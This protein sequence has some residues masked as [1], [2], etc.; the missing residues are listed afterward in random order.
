M[1]TDEVLNVID[2][3]LQEVNSDQKER[4]ARIVQ[5]QK[6]LSYN[7]RLTK[8]TDEEKE[9]FVESVEGGHMTDEMRKTIDNCKTK[10]QK[11]HYYDMWARSTYFRKCA[12]MSYLHGET[13][14]KPFASK[15]K[16][17]TTSTN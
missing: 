10:E 1:K 12:W 2:E 14:D 6:Y 17:I 16:S 5:I 4:I 8:L 13:N 3:H 11:D 7:L 15:E 9:N